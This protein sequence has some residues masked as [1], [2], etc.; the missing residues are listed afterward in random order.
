MNLLLRDLV[1]TGLFDT[2]ILDLSFFAHSSL[3]TCVGLQQ[4][5]GNVINQCFDGEFYP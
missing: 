1:H 4:C 5:R 2:T 3:H